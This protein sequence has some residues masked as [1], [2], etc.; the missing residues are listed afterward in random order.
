M[1]RHARD[2]REHLAG[3]VDGAP[4]ARTWKAQLHCDAIAILFSSSI[5]QLAGLLNARFFLRPRDRDPQDLR[6]R[7][8]AR[9]FRGGLVSGIKIL[10]D[11]REAGESG[12][13]TP[14]SER[15]RVPYDAL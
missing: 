10:R 5:R 6:V 3:K 15:A 14:K 4:K 7:G 9:D 2:A 11:P 8:A 12:G 1:R 13:R